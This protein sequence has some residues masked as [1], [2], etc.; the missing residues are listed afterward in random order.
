MKLVK[1][2]FELQFIATDSNGN[3]DVPFR[4]LFARKLFAPKAFTRELLANE[5]LGWRKR[6]S[7]ARQPHF[8]F[9]SSESAI[10]T[11]V[12]ETFIR[13]I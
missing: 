12:T 11:W 8:Y 7:R 13:I 4:G 9:L 5:T 1:K 3:L 10:I 6:V 2:N